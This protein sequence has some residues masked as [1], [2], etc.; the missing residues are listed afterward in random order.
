M[1]DG[2][3]PDGMVPWAGGDS[4]PAD[5]DGGAVLARDGFV[6]VKKPGAYQW[7]RARGGA[8]Q[9]W[10]IIAYTPRAAADRQTEQL[11][12]HI[13]QLE[14]VGDP[15]H[16]AEQPGMVLVPR[17]ATHEAEEAGARILAD[18]ASRKWGALDADGQETFRWRARKIWPAMIAAALAPA[19]GEEG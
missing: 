12:A 17:V 11:S 19:S 7:R 1:T 16:S 2:T 18:C 5:W 14:K 8:K 4:A 13:G 10:D 9:D 15:N 3:I 6:M